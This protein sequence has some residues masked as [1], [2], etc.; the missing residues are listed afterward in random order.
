MAASIL[1]SMMSVPGI[2]ERF[3]E[4]AKEIPADV[5]C[6]DLE[7]SVAEPQKAAAR[8]MVADAIRDFPAKGRLLY[9]R[10]NGLDTGLAELDLDAVVGPWLHGINIPKAES[11]AVIHQIDHYLTFLEKT[12]DMEPG[13]VTLIPWIETTEG[14]ARSHEIC[15]ASPRLIGAALG[16]E[17]FVTSLGVHRTREGTELEYP[18]ANVAVAARAAGLVPIDAPESDFR[19]LEH[20]HKVVT[21]ARGLGYRGKFCI[22]PSQVEVANRVFAPSAEDVGWARRVVEAYEEGER[23]GLGAIA[24][25]GA[26]IDRPI[27][28]RAY[29]LLDWQHQVEEQEAALR[30]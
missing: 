2:R 20:F 9:V 21:H 25:D 24:L 14:L 10:I 23:Q 28:V 18:R 11:A 17:D 5:I 30:P 29:E 7:D 22:H 15:T 3:L 19:D 13:H 16:G 4:R 1:R 6:F 26:M 27:V 12:R 8:A